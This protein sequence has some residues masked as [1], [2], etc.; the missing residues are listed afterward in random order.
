MIHNRN[1][2]LNC[3]GYVFWLGQVRSLVLNTSE[4]RAVDPTWRG[5]QRRQNRLMSECNQIILGRT[6]GCLNVVNHT[7]PAFQGLRE[8]PDLYRIGAQL[9]EKLFVHAGSGDWNECRMKCAVIMNRVVQ[10]GGL[11]GPP[12]NVFTSSSRGQ[13]QPGT[14][15]SRTQ[16]PRRESSRPLRSYPNTSRACASGKKKITLQRIWSCKARRPTC[17]ACAQLR[18]QP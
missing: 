4:S 13:L 1:R 14:A 11:H 2:L 15:F 5:F 17:L 7:C 8:I 16:R 3:N 6:Q 9:Q 18:I 12:V 10:I